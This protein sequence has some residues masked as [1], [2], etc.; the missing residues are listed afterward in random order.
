MTPWVVALTRAQL[1]A[2]VRPE[3]VQVPADVPT[4]K[5]NLFKWLSA[6]VDML[7]LDQVGIAHCWETT[8]LLR[9]WEHGVQAEAMQRASEIFPNLVRATALTVH[10]DS[11]SATRATRT[12][13]PAS[14][15]HPLCS[16]RTTRSGWST[17]TGARSRRRRA[18][19]AA[20]ALDRLY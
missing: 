13:R 2:G 17:S 11:R 16:P 12:R 3:E 6:A 4:C 18:A 15:A 1:S 7:N 19:A 14:L 9:A 5:E 8:Q 20:A 10:Q